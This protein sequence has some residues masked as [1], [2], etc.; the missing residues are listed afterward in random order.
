MYIRTDC[1]VLSHKNF[2]EADR[3]LTLYT[4]DFGK[5]SCLAKGVR[6]LTSRKAG[7]VEPGNWCKVFIA[8]GKNL[9]LLTEAELKKAFGAREPTPTKAGNIFHLLELVSELTEINQKNS[10]VFSLLVDFLDKTD[11]GEDFNLV[12]AAFKIKLL[13][14]LGFFSVRSFQSSVTR[15]LIKFFEEEDYARLKQKLVISENSYLKLLSFLDS[16]IESLTERK[17]KTARF[18]NGKF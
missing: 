10:E 6:R 5:M 9:D 12:S 17:L 13:S 14:A 1:V 8:K 18:V 3:I 4:K 2:N 16:I 7:H 11:R 15:D